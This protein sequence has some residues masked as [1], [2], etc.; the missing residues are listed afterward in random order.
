M[1]VKGKLGAFA[2]LREDY[3]HGGWMA[4]PEEMYQCQTVNY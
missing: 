4:E 2:S 1:I 3:H